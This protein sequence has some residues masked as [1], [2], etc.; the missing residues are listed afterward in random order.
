MA[1]KPENDDATWVDETSAALRDAGYK[2]IRFGEFGM[3]YVGQVDYD[4][5]PDGH[6][7]MYLKNGDV[8]EC[9]FRNG[10]A[11]GEGVYVSSKGIEWKGRWEANK[12]TGQFAVVDSTGTHWTEKYD[13]EGKR[14]ARKKLREAVPNEK[15][16]AGGEE[17]ETIEVEVPKDE[18]AMQCY[19]CNG[20]ARDRNNHAWACRAHSGR[21]TEDRTYRGEGE[22][23]GVW[24]C[25]G[26]EERSEPG[27]AFRSHNFMSA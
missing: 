7:Y 8:H 22:A 24:S 9:E 10:R 19:F 5:K 20:K 11:N 17:P 21:F 25:C 27:C 14:V 26:R 1:D 2:I 4:N 3:V 6:G 16:V 13:A 12:K 23:P 18:A 15:F